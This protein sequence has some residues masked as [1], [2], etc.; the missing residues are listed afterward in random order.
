MNILWFSEIRW[1]YLKTRKQHLL[2]LFPNEDKILFIQPLSLSKNK[3]PIE[4][5][6]NIINK[7]VPIFR[8]GNRTLIKIAKFSIIRIIT[9]NLLL[10]YLKFLIKQHLNDDIHVIC[11]S[12]IFFVP[13]LDK[14]KYP[15]IWDFND[16]PKQFGEIPNWVYKYYYNLLSDK[17]TK[18]I[19]SSKGFNN[20]I[21][22]KFSNKP[23]TI[24]NGVDREKFQKQNVLSNNNKIIFGYVGIISKWFFDFNLIKKISTTYPE[25]EI[26]IYGPKD[27][28]ALD[29][30]NDI[31]ELNNVNIFP[32]QE[33]DMLPEI[34]RK[35]SIGLVPLQSCDKVTRVASGKLL[36]YL[37]LGLPVVSVYMEQFEGLSNLIMCRNH[38]EFM[39][40]I[41]YYINNDILQDNDVEL[42]KYDWKV[43]ADQYR[44]ELNS[45]IS[46]H[47][48]N[49]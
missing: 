26:K 22:S 28:N 11:V 49:K 34:M 7:T 23:I 48:N 16:D 2:S 45:S 38:S 17:N 47:K 29:L 33:Y 5:P 31:S 35:F 4:H 8:R 12:N 15:I 32:K 13:L 25:C 6:K 42:T 20:Y 9:Y 21:Y 3:F 30:I 24:S 43:L 46:K 14:F 44:I 1:D 10:R 36:Q 27:K 18:I 19:S 41:D 40:G 39:D 37:S